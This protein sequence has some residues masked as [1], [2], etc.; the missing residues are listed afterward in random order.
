[1]RYQTAAG[2]RCEESYRLLRINGLRLVRAGHGQQARALA[3][4]M[5]RRLPLHGAN[6]SG[7][8]LQGA[9]L[10]G[11]DLEGANLHGVILDGVELIEGG[12]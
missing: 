3:A 6:L 11:A 10:R 12:S 2:W 9:D 7:A 5:G 4:A 1:V 8:D